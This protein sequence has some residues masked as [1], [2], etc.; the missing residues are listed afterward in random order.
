M[1]KLSKADPSVNR[2]ARRSLM[3]DKCPRIVENVGNDAET[4]LCWK[5]VFKLLPHDELDT[6]LTLLRK[7][8]PP[9]W[10][11][12]EQFVDVEGNVY[13]YGT[14][15]TELKGKIPAT[16]YT[17]I[18]PTIKKVRKQRKKR[19]KNVE[20]KKHQEDVNERIKQLKESN[21]L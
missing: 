6:K 8:Y 5:C 15:V 17:P 12:M 13:R 1:K 20:R 2:R 21:E 19:D 7:T 16:E 3:C 14:A 4:V 18:D 11:S 9:R 10:K